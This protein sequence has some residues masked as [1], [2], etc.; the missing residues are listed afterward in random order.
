MDRIKFADQIMTD[1]GREKFLQ[2]FRYK[3]VQ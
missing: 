3:I 2:Y 1:C